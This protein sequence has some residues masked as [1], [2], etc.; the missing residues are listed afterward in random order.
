MKEEMIEKIIRYDFLAFSISRWNSQSHM[1]HMLQKQPKRAYKQ[2]IR[3][4]EVRG[5]KEK[6][7]KRYSLAICAKQ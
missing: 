3:Y 1:S 2:F 6:R 7:E 5:G 4:R